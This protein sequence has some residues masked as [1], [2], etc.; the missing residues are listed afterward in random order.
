MKPTAGL[1]SVGTIPALW[2]LGIEPSYSLACA[3]AFPLRHL[4]LAS[5]NN[6]V[7]QGK[8]S[9]F[10]AIIWSGVANVPTQARAELG[11]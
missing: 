8:H 5:L 4:P 3:S 6:T 1:Q 9:G 11:G 10:L 2:R 7:H